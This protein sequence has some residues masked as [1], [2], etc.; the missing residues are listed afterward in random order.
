MTE[1]LAMAWWLV[2]LLLVGG[3]AGGLFVGG[4]YLL[5]E[6]ADKRP[7]WFFG[8]LL[9]T[10]SFTLFHNFLIH[11]NI[12]T[13]RPG[14]LFLPVYFTLSLGPLLFFFVKIKL[15]P[16]YQIRFSDAKHLILPAAQFLYFCYMFLQPAAYRQEVG[17]EFYSPFYGGVE[18]LLYIG[19]FWAYHYFAYRYIRSKSLQNKN[20]QV[21][22]AALQVAWLKRMVKVLF[23]LFFLNAAYILTDFFSYEIFGLNLHLLTGFG[24]VGS[25]SLASML[26]WLTFNGWVMRRV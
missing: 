1:V 21:P 5:R 19:G 2:L 13:E 3:V 6:T 25:L 23:V 8:M 18:M 17:R 15:Y 20:P 11:L 16:A 7:D 9:I 10:L 12:F 22:A 14:W 4:Y 24:H 26:Y